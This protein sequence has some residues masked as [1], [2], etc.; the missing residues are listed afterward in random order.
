[1]P[2]SFEFDILLLLRVA[3]TFSEAEGLDLNFD[4]QKTYLVKAFW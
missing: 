4:W 1:M 2:D 3:A